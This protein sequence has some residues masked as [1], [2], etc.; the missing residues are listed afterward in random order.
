M[1][2]YQ[3]TGGIGYGFSQAVILFGNPSRAT[4]RAPGIA[5]VPGR[6]LPFLRRRDGC[7]SGG[8]GRPRSQGGLEARRDALR[9]ERG[10]PLG[11]DLGRERPQRRLDTLMRR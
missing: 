2:E 5:A 7:C 8:R 11:R 4:D 1:Q 3:H 9:L 10:F 6:N